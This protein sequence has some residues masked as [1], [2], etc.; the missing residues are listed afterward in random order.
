MSPATNYLFVRCLNGVCFMAEHDLVGVITVTYNSASVVPDFMQSLLKQSHWKFM[1]YVV[2][3]ASSDNTV[4]L[5]TTY[6]DS[7]LRLLQN[8]ENVGVA[9]GNNIG[10][11]AALENGCSSVL[12]INND[13]VFDVDMLSTLLCGL[14]QYNCDMIVPKILY[15]EPSNTLWCAG[16]TFSTWRGAANHFGFG[17]KDDGKF[18]QVREVQYS[19][20]CCMLI[21]KTVF[22]SIGLM[23]PKFFVYFDDT[24]F[25]LRAC[26]RKIRLI[27]VPSVRIYHKVST[28]IGHRSDLSLR[29]FTRN[30]VYYVMKNFRPWMMLYYLPICQAH[31]F[32]RALVAKGKMRALSIAERAF[33]EG[34][35][36]FCAESRPT[37]RSLHL[38]SQNR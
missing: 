14:Q 36:L 9:E 18:D 17:Q 15:F 33:W 6:K 10:I 1:L 16:G 8:S 7:R 35:V 2:D 29:Y 12:L 21:K 30:H 24:D 23:D 4:E 11:K 31:V 34:I 13:T 32:R 25:C 28:L 27:Y 19:P 5:L 20:T 26:R 22:D 37:K 38:A 3:N